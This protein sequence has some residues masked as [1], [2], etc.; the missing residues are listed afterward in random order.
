MSKKILFENEA[1]NSLLKGVNIVADAVKVTIGARGRNVIID[2]EGQYP[3]IINDGVTIAKEI[4]LEDP[5]ENAG[6]KLLKQICSNTNDAVGDG[7][8]TSSIL[9]QSIIQNGLKLVEEGINPILMKKGIDLATDFCIKELDNIAIKVEDNETIKQVASISA[10]GNEFIGNLIAEAMAEVGNDGIVAFEE[11]CRPETTLKV[12]KGMEFDRGYISKNFCKNDEQKEITMNDVLVFILDEKIT[13]FGD[14]YEIIQKVS[15][16][17][18]NILIIADELEGEALGTLMLNN[19]RGLL[20]VVAVQAP[21]YN[22]KRANTLEDIAITTGTRVFSKSNGYNPKTIE[23][24]DLGEAKSITVTKDKT[25]IVTKEGMK[26]A[27]QERADFIRHELDKAESNY[28]K[29]TLKDRLARLSGGVALIQIGANSEAELKELKY[30]IEDAL[31]ATRASIEEGIVAGG[32]TALIE[33]IK[34]IAEKDLTNMSFEES[35]GFE[36]V[37]NSLETPLFNIAKNCGED[38]ISVINTIKA[39]DEKNMGYD[40]LTGEYVDM[41]K[42]GIIDPVKVTKS[43]LRNASSVASILLTTEVAIFN[44]KREGE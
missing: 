1:R 26:D 14:I 39:Y 19:S 20:K 37:I 33:V 2:R 40:A 7:T 31:N 28:E 35:K 17:D 43:A 18:R 9:A 22:E 30:R 44:N 4:E 16:E 23:I 36:I 10:G 3:L 12:V 42:A 29:E 6:A 32:G 8:T 11:T 13:F 34:R 15:D 5:L 38:G 41:I 24:S 27:I 21:F 25:I